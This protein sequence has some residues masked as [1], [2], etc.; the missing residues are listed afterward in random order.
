M[1]GEVCAGSF[2]G[3]SGSGSGSGW[4]L[5]EPPLSSG[6]GPCSVASADRTDH[7]SSSEFLALFRGEL[8]SSSVRT[9]AS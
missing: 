5:L 7:S 4:L 3:P 9:L 1:D 6:K 8:P 2:P